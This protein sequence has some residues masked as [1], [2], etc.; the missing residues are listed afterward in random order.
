SSDRK[1]SSPMHLGQELGAPRGAART[2]ER[3]YAMAALLV[4]LSV[5]AVLMSVGLAVWSQVARREREEE[6]ICRGQ[7][8]ARAVG[9][10][11]R[12]FA[13][14]FPPTIDILVEQRFLRKKYKDP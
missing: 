2:S 4:G 6:L 7:Q 5:M 1:Y 12:K 3:G 14:T 8:Y 11:Q 9:L 10:F 13:N